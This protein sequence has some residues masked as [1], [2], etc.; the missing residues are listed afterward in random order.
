MKGGIKKRKGKKK[1]GRER[2]GIDVLYRE[3]T[4]S[5]QLLKV[6]AMGEDE[7]CVMH[8]EGPVSGWGC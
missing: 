6:T 2:L 8:E 5:Q 7:G 1:K 4:G 3:V